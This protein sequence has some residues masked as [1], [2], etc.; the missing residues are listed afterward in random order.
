MILMA[1]LM[2]S[3]ARQ[4]LCFWWIDWSWLWNVCFCSFE[5]SLSQCRRHSMCIVI[6]YWTAYQWPTGSKVIGQVSAVTL[7][8]SATYRPWAAHR[9]TELQGSKRA[10][11][12]IDHDCSNDDVFMDII[13][14][15]RV[16]SGHLYFM[17]H[18]SWPSC[19]FHVG[20]PIAIYARL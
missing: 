9:V 11:H 10:L 15:C 14:T 7:A 19:T 6:F 13:Y 20:Y 16:Y 2:H 4:K 8:Y 12:L 5:Y 1:A 3:I 18:C 17:L